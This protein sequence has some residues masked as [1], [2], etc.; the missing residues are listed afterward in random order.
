MKKDNETMKKNL[1]L[2][3][4]IV[5]LLLTFSVSAVAVVLRNV[6][7]LDSEYFP[8]FALSG[9]IILVLAIVLIVA[10]RKQL[11]YR[12]AVPKFNQIWKP[13]LFGLLTS[14]VLGI[15]TGII[16]TV[17]HGKIEGHPALMHASVLQFVLFTLILAPV[18]E[19]HLFRGFLQNYLKPLGNKGITVFRRRIS[20]PVLI[21]ALA[22]SLSHLGLLAS[23]VGA[24]FM[25]RTVLFTF[26]LGTIAGYYQEKYNN[27]VLAILVHMAGNLLGMLPVVLLNV[28]KNYM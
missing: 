10:F 26:I 4:L 14:L 28:L 24:A 15:I 2:S 25:I 9:F 17:L 6:V 11:D 27:I 16:T 12:I 18:A 1:V 8:N 23:G 22:F 3:R 13:V 7:K 19:E 5:G 21:A 20:L